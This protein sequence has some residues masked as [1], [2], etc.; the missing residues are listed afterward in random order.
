MCISC[1]SNLTQECNDSPVPQN[2]SVHLS[3]VSQHLSEEDEPTGRE[4]SSSPPRGILKY[5]PSC[6]FTD[7][8][9]SQD[10]QSSPK[11]PDSPT[12]TI[13]A[14]DREA[15]G[16]IDRKQVR[17][18]P[19]VGCGGVKRQ[20]GKELGEH[21]VLDTD[22]INPTDEENNNKSLN[23]GSNLTEMRRPLVK[24]R[25]V[26]LDADDLSFQKEAKLLNRECDQH[27]VPSGKSLTEN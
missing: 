9:C 23:A 13:L 7:S 2:A 25:E 20:D 22:S 16:W 6:S 17:F 12:E 8:V 19:A 4:S 14:Q 3:E 1:A 21:S 11:A 24:Q 10:D 27:Q 5:V 18:S 15:R 26:D